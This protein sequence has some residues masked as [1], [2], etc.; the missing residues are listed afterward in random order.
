MIPRFVPVAE[1]RP[2]EV[3]APVKEML[4]TVTPG[5]SKTSCTSCP[6]DIELVVS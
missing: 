1:N 5:P 4:D 2:M 3:E 6:G